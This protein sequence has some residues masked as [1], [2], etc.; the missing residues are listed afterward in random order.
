MTAPSNRDELI[1]QRAHEIWLR[2]GRPSGREDQHWHQ[3][4]D[5][6]A[7]EEDGSLSVAGEEDP[8]PMPAIP[9]PS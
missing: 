2:E 4:K 5:E 7:V 9:T 6:V 8:E 3:A 1:R